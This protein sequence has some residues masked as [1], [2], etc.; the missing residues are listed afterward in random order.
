MLW[1]MV[2]LTAL[3]GKTDGPPD[4]LRARSCACKV[5]ATHADLMHHV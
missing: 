4:L 2:G 3:L 5:G 1:H